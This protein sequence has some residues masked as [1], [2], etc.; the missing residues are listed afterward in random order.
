MYCSHSAQEEKAKK[1]SDRAHPSKNGEWLHWQEASDSDGNQQTGSI[2]VKRRRREFDV[3]LNELDDFCKM[4]FLKIGLKQTRKSCKIL[5]IFSA[6]IV[7]TSSVNSSTINARTNGAKKKSD[8]TV[9]ISRAPSRS[10]NRTQIAKT[11]AKSQERR[12]IVSYAKTVWTS[13]IKI[14][15]EIFKS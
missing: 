2:C 10:P 11:N 13:L 7:I 6:K 14:F 8:G 5:K 4:N 1:R 15:Y 12:S 3:N 9:E